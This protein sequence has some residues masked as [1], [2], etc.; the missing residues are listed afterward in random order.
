MA[1]TADE[2]GA[3]VEAGIKWLGEHDPKGVFAL[4]Q[5]AGIS[6]RARLPALT[7]DEH[8]HYIEGRAEK[9]AEWHH[10]FGIWNQLY[11]AW[12][13]ALRREGRA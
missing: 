13:L 1:P 12:E 7:N 4:W 8:P 9:Y 3:R 2:L 10:Q 5:Q 11:D 6:P